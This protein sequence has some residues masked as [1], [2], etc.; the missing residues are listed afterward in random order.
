[1]WRELGPA[2]PHSQSYGLRNQ[3]MLFL[4]LR[5]LA[6]CDNNPEKLTQVLKPLVAFSQGP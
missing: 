1:M 5:L 6:F 3:E 4:C 2:E